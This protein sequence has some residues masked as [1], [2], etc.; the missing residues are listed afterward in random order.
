MGTQRISPD[1]RN[2]PQCKRQKSVR[3]AYTATSIF[4]RSLMLVQFATYSIT[5]QGVISFPDF[6][7]V[8]PFEE[9]CRI[10]TGL[11]GIYIPRHSTAVKITDRVD[12]F[13]TF[14]LWFRNWP[15]RRDL[16]P[17]HLP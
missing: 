4:M 11:D 8:R 1:E 10:I 13:L 16:N 2:I 17:R 9:T 12:A 7:F 14:T 3:R 5:L 15:G 6:V